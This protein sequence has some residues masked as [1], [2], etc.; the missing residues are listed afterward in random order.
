MVEVIHK[1]I[2]TDYYDE[3]CIKYDISEIVIPSYIKNKKE[4]IDNQIHNNYAILLIIKEPHN[5]GI[6]MNYEIGMRF[7]WIESCIQEKTYNNY[8][9]MKII[10]IDKK[11]NDYVLVFHIEQWN[12][13]K[14][15]YFWNWIKLIN[16]N[17]I[18]KIKENSNDKNK[19]KYDI[20]FLDDLYWRYE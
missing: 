17:G 7:Y 4:F 2:E 15:L 5:I 8:Y 18:E 6:W 11:V 16:R 14:L 1:F 20:Q 9:N 12:Y 19:H 10:E 3:L 13:I